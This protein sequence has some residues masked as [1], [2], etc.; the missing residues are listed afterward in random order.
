MQAEGTVCMRIA[1]ESF[2]L[3]DLL[4]FCTTELKCSD[5]SDED[6]EVTLSHSHIKPGGQ[7]AC[8]SWC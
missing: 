8:T 4:Y 6:A 3:M 5:V 7:P 2:Q 1:K